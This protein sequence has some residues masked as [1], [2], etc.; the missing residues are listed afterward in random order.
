MKQFPSG[1]TAPIAIMRDQ[2]ASASTYTTVLFPTW[3]RRLTI[4]NEN[5]TSSL[6]V[7]FRPQA[8]DGMTAQ[9]TPGTGA[10]AENYVKIIPSAS[11]SF[12]VTHGRDQN[13]GRISG[14]AAGLNVASLSY[15]TSSWGEIGQVSTNGFLPFPAFHVASRDG[16]DSVFVAVGEAN[17]Q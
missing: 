10:T 17:E 13:F 7:T 6:R 9:A 12:A 5:A 16:A 2:V 15:I 4:Y 8:F 11:F 1:S 14:S 3:V